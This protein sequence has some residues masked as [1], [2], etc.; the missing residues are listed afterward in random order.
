MKNLLSGLLSLIKIKTLCANKIWKPDYEQT[1]ISSWT[2]RL[3][4]QGK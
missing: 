1:T 4:W 2:T 3:T